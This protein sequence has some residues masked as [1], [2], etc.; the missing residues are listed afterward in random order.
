MSEFL[1]S[2]LKSIKEYF[3]AVWIKLIAQLII[4]LLIVVM[5]IASTRLL[6]KRFRIQKY[7]FKQFIER[8]EEFSDYTPGEG[9]SVIQLATK[10]NAMFN[11][12]LDTLHDNVEDPHWDFKA[13]VAD[14]RPD[15]KVYENE[16]FTSSYLPTVVAFASSMRKVGSLNKNEHVIEYVFHVA[17]KKIELLVISNQDNVVNQSSEG[18]MNKATVSKGTF[19]DI[20]AA[21][22]D[23]DY[24]QIINVLFDKV[25][26]KL[27][28]TADNNGSLQ[29][30]P[31][32]QGYDQNEYVPDETFLSSI[33]RQIKEFKNRGYQR[34][35]IFWGQ[36]GTGKSLTSLAL[37]SR[38]EGRV[39]KID[40]S[41]IRQFNENKMLRQFFLKLDA[42]LIVL[43]D[44]DHFMDSLNQNQTFLYILE[45][46]KT[47]EHKTALVMTVNDISRLN[48]A[49]LRP[50]RVDQIIEFKAPNKQERELFIRRLLVEKFN[51]TIP[52]SNHVEQLTKATVGMTQAYIKEWVRLYLVE[53]MKID[54]VLEAIKQR[55][56]IMKVARIDIDDE[57]A[58][59]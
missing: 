20:F 31:V 47:L 22:N 23:E 2:L 8:V 38:T 56:R 29:I 14:K 55:K 35:F 27:H 21:K 48:A 41:F 54:T 10:S 42:N 6:P 49:F 4:F 5:Y 26:N 1:K 9:D 32:D 46:M 30:S 33:E 50:G 25:S 12:I 13:F 28:L 36:P 39:L 37:A 15:L 59:E 34:T 58:N 40:S 19:E 52:D 18:K 57:E 44:V 51:T 3:Q 7:R 16:D 11:R 17:D 45:S 24:Y 53:D 43:D